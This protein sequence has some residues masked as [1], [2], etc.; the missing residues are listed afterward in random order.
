[1]S[2]TAEGQRISLPWAIMCMLASL[3]VAIALNETL[4]HGHGKAIFFGIFV[5]AFIAK[6]YRHAVGQR[7]V[8]AFLL[9]VAA[10]H[11]LLVFI[12]PSDNQYPGGLLFPAG[13]IDIALFYY[14]FGIIVKR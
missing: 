2:E 14:L 9:C 7:R 13:L 5:T 12:I 6:T 3:V 4:A 11:G 10:F 8:A 1:V